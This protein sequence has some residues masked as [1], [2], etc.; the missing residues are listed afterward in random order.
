MPIALRRGLALPDLLI[1]LL[2]LGLVA[3]LAV[4]LT[5]A[6]GR[7]LRGLRERAALQSALTTSFTLLA[8]DLS[9]L[10]PG[11]LQQSLPDLMQYRAFRSSGLACSV[12]GS[13]VLVLV[14]YFSAARLPQAGRDSLLVYAGR[15]PSSVPSDQWLAAPLTGVGRSDCAGR[16]AYRLA[17]VLDSTRLA[18]GLQTG[19]VPVR[20]FEVVQARIYQ[21]LGAWWLGVRSVSA[22]EPLQPVVG[23]FEVIGTRFS[24]FDSSG[25]GTWTPQA[26]RR[27]GVTLAGRTADW[28]GA[29]AVRDSAELTLSPPNLWP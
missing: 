25:S 27:L 19:L 22:G 5:L 14:D 18:A 23:P 11:D 24:Y 3:T 12:R 21:S 6:H 17:T 9:D 8:A 13:E 15:P 20:T 16:P 1:G 2:V 10:A 26:V 7:L 28:S 29:M 4:K